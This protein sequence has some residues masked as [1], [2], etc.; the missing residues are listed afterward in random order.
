MTYM[1]KY[2]L[3]N[4]ERIDAKNKEYQEKNK[5]RLQK[6]RREYY[7]TYDAK[8]RFKKIKE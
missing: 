1:Q 2:Y 8:K 4:K 6:Y 7:Q 3:E 5:E